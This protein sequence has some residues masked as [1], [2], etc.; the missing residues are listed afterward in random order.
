ML[1]L[2]VSTEIAAAARRPRL[3]DNAT[4][5][6]HI[7]QAIMTCGGTVDH[8]VDTV[9]NYPTLSESYKIAALDAA[10]KMRAV[11]RLTG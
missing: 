7:G 4:E 9:F 2:L 1:K 10:N 8:L 11:Q 3:R 5:L 6:V